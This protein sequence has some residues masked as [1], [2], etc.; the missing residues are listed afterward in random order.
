M[1]SAAGPAAIDALLVRRLLAEQFPAWADLPVRAAE[2]QGWD[3]RTFRMGSELAARL[4]SGPGYALQPEKE[5]RWLPRLAPHLPVPIPEV[6]AH[7]RPGAGYPYAWSVLRWRPGTPALIGRIAG[8]DRFAA[9]LAAFLV[10]LRGVDASEGPAPGP[11]NFLRGA[12]PEVYADEVERS[13]A[14]L[15]GEVPD[16][17]LRRLWDRAL[18]SRWDR[19]LVW[20]H[21]DVAAGNLLL[22]DAGRLAAVLDFG[23]SAVG[24]PACDL[25]V[26]WTLLPPSARQV[27]RRTVDLDDETW[28]RA[29]GWLLWKALLVL[30]RALEDGDEP[31]AAAPRR[32]L[33]R[34]LAEPED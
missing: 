25:V 13:L 10:A 20:L 26:A 21:G 19:E 32:E 11:H 30:E 28:A 24:D 23:C 14:T 29:R 1:T 34:V 3:N 2:P 18:A 12:P 17:G 4:P 31:A 5:W 27:F 6:V 8:T 9:D 7:G 15:A 22:D 16:A 33:L